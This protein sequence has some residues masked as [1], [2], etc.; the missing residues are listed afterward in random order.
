[1]THVHESLAFNQ[2]K[3]AMTQLHPLSLR[4]GT[5]GRN[6][7]HTANQGPGVALLLCI[8]SFKSAAILSEVLF[9]TPGHG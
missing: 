7:H 6:G 1:M 5:E 3:C 2:T 8:H 9:L 4:K